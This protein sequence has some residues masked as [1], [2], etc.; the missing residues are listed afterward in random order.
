MDYPIAL[1]S[2]LSNSSNAHPVITLVPTQ[3]RLEAQIFADRNDWA[4]RQKWTMKPH[5]EGSNGWLIDSYSFTI[6]WQDATWALTF[7]QAQQPVRVEKYDPYSSNQRWYVFKQ[8]GPQE[9]FSVALASASSADPVCLDLFQSHTTDGSPVYAWQ[10]QNT[11]KNTNQ[12]WGRRIGG[13]PKLSQTPSCVA[14]VEQILQAAQ[15]NPYL[16]GNLFS[17][18]APIFA[19]AG[20]PMQIEDYRAFNRYFLTTTEPMLEALAR[21]ADHRDLASG[22]CIVCKVGFWSIAAMLAG[23]GAA[24][25]A[26]LSVGAAPV[27]ALST[28]TGIAA[29][30]VLAFVHGL[31][32]LTVFTVDSILL[33]ICEWIGVC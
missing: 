10:Y 6:N 13:T 28:A 17:D 5:I 4:D 18:P 21:G 19:A 22:K 3:S 7:E 33:S 25:L 29:T 11:D 32:A 9:L 1:A 27:V 24:G 31:V 26:F 30:S 12:F 23:V 8:K 20:Y 2:L 16:I 15:G 14:V